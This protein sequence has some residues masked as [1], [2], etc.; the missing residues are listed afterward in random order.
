[1][2][3]F[4]QYDIIWDQDSK[5]YAFLPSDNGKYVLA[6]DARHLRS[7]LEDKE[8]ELQAQMFINEKLK[9]DLI[10]FDTLL[11]RSHFLFCPKCLLQLNNNNLRVQKCYSCGHVWVLPSGF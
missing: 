10:K 8:N 9:S 3:K 11:K 4:T 5:E 6:D 1:M 7:L 2:N